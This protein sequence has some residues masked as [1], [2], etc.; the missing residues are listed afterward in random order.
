[1][2]NGWLSARRLSRHELLDDTTEAG[3]SRA[4][5]RLPSPPLSPLASLSRAEARLP[6]PPSPAFSQRGRLSHGERPASAASLPL[7]QRGSRASVG[8]A[9]RGSEEV[10]AGLEEVVAVEAGWVWLGVDRVAPLQH[11]LTQA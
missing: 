6:S 5:A 4:E 3:L 9:S 1:M 10:E 7:S 11:A 8:L 2:L